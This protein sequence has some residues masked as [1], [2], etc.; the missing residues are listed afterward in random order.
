MFT[1]ALIGGTASAVP[2]IIR[3]TI[4]VPFFETRV[5]HDCRPGVTRTVVAT[6]VFS[7]HTVET[8]RAFHIEGTD[9]GTCRIDW[10]DGSYTLIEFAQSLGPS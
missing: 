5:P 9:T 8:A 4:A 2:I 6:E 10:S 3:D 1:A 7:F